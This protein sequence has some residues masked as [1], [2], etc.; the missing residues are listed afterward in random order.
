[1]Y[2]TIVLI[3]RALYNQ[4]MAAFSST[5]SRVRVLCLL[6]LV[7]VLVVGLVVVV[8]LGGS[9]FDYFVACFGGFG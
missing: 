6:V 3:P 9:R 5:Q 1:M 2:S 7:V 8:C 4:D